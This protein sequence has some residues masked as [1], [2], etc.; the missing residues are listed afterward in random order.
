M[1][2]LDTLVTDHL[3]AELLQPERTPRRTACL[4]GSAGDLTMS[5]A[6]A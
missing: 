6:L 4:G 5:T 2:K 3:V 1:G